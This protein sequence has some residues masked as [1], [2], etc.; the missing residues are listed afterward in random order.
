MVRTRQKCQ[1]CKGPQKAIFWFGSGK[2][3][4]YCSP[5]CQDKAEGYTFSRLTGKPLK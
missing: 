5:D 4:F 1:Q 2:G 3:Y